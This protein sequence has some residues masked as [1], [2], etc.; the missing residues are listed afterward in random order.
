[1]SVNIQSKKLHDVALD[2]E[3]IQENVD[4][5]QENVDDIQE[6]IEVIADDI[7][8][9]EEDEDEDDDILSRIEGNIE[10]L[11][12]ELVKLKQQQAKRNFNHK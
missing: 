10:I 7:K 8:E 6:N 2:V 9:D 11:M 12:K 1:M 3:D 5:I 4:D